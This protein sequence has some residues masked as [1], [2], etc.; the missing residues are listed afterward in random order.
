[1][2]LLKGA[3]SFRKSKKSA[4]SAATSDAGTSAAPSSDSP[5]LINNESDAAA[6]MAPN[7]AE[8]RQDSSPS[9]PTASPSSPPG[10]PLSQSLNLRPLRLGS[11]NF[12][13]PESNTSAVN[14]EAMPQTHRLTFPLLYHEADDMLNLSNLIY[15]LAELRDLARNG[16]LNNPVQS[17]R[18]LEVPLP[19]DTALKII[20]SEG[21]LLREVLDDGKHEA[22]LSALESLLARQDEKR[23]AKD[24][25]DTADTADTKT[26]KTEDSGVFG[27]MT[28]WDGCLAGGFSFDEL[29]CGD[30]SHVNDAAAAA[31]SKEQQGVSSSM[32]TA[33]GDLKSSA[34][35]VYAVGINP[36]EERI[37][38]V[39]RG[40]VTKNDFMTDANIHMVNAPDPRKFNGVETL[41]GSDSVGDVGVHQ[42][43]YEYL[44][45]SGKYAE[46]TKHVAKLMSENPARK[47]YKL[48]VTGHSLGGALATLFGFYAA[49]STSLPLPV[50]VVSVAS[51]RVGNISFARTFAELESQ[52]KLRH[53]RIAN[54]KDPVTLGPTVSSKRALALSAKAFSPLG[55]LALVVTGNGEGGDEE[56]YYHTGIKMKLLKSVSAISSQRFEI[57]YSGASIISGAKKPVA[58][59]K[60]DLAEIEQSNKRKKKESSSELPMVSYHYGTSYSERLASVESD[61]QGLALNDV[62]A[63]K[64]CG[65]R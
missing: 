39:F 6:G 18:I 30:L 26:H 24:T 31:N 52:G 34:E 23:P 62:Y 4:S 37:T 61:L 50:T 35:L 25:A 51:P 27:W 14:G 21:G 56:V 47:N 10:S 17:V 44:F 13:N 1:M 22:T 65:M 40:S 12:D 3:R 7:E 2:K 20:S 9:S 64:A 42:G 63:E 57:S 58:I 46:I 53:L 32:I 19:L 60:D 28:N 38:I 33:V 11:F 5:T 16:V 48:Y 36:I 54:N 29:F 43:F 15:T 55:Y 59:D 45:K 8:T 41:G 49:A